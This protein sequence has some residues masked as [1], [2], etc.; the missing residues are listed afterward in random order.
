MLLKTILENISHS[1][2]YNLLNS[3][4]DNPEILSFRFYQESSQPNAYTLYLLE[5]PQKTLPSAGH[6]LAI[7]IP[8]SSDFS[9]VIFVKTEASIMT[10]F[11]KLEEIFE[12]ESQIS[13]D[14]RALYR[15]AYNFPDIQI[16]FQKVHDIIRHDLLIISNTLEVVGA[17][18]ESPNLSSFVTIDKKI[19]LSSDTIQR[20]HSDRLFFNLRSKTTA[21]QIDS[22]YFG[23]PTIITP[24]QTGKN[25]I[26]YLCILQSSHIFNSNDFALAEYISELAG[27]TVYMRPL[28]NNLYTE[29][30]NQDYFLNTLLYNPINNLALYAP[31]FGWEKYLHHKYYQLLICS[32]PSAN[33]RQAQFHFYHQFQKI[34]ATFPTAQITNICVVILYGDTPNLLSSYQLDKLTNLLSLQDQNGLLSFPFSDLS[35]TSF[36]YK[37]CC[38]L[39]QNSLFTSNHVLETME[40][41]YLA[42][43]SNI[44]IEHD[45]IQLYIHPD[46]LYLKEYDQ[47]HN[48][49]LTKTLYAYLKN[50]RNIIEMAKVLH[51]GKS[52]GFYRINQ[53]KELVNDPFS[54][55]QRVFCYECA[56]QL[57]K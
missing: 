28:Q 56:L 2:N 44:Y 36:Y 11:N 54:D 32:T 52:T 10:F 17:Y 23:R 8:P 51:I 7:N 29:N 14:F 20:I 5:A 40:K 41:M 1:I 46:I 39:L 6:Y 19:C 12:Q 9:N 53:I 22:K 43:L 48:S 21:T 15:I 55:F 24:I 38:R 31:I 34:F 16:F 57:D 25:I 18:I 33:N 30:I 26:G 47:K 3:F 50:G 13:R 35:K 49:E 37:H 42:F 27:Q 45:D 4:D